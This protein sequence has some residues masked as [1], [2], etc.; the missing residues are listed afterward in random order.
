M[1]AMIPHRSVAVLA[2]RSAHI[3]DSRLRELADDIIE[4]QMRE[5]AEMKRLIAELQRN[6]AP[7]NAA[8]LPPR[9][10]NGDEA[11]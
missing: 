11:G 6:P 2:S 10:A 4:A 7:A 1:K 5:I 9:P 8:D 3:R